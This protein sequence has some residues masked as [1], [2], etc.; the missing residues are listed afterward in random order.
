MAV[1]LICE[2]NP[3][4]NGHK[5]IIGEARRLTGEPVVAIMSGSF[6]QRGEA[7][8]C[9]KFDRARMALE[10]GADLVVELPTVYAV[11]G[12]QRF[13]QGGVE[14]AKSF[15][16]VRWL[17]FG[18]DCS[19]GSVLQEAADALQNPAVNARIAAQMRGG[20]Y[21][22]QAVERAVRS[23]CGDA[24]ADALT[25]PNNI[26][27]AEYL[28][29]LGGSDIRPLPVRRIGAAHD[30]DEVSGSY[31]SASK[32]RSMLR[33]GVAVDGLLP[34]VPQ[35]IT[36]P[37]L[38]E[39]ALLLRLRSMTAADFQKLPEVGEGLEHRIAAAVAENCSV[40]EILS[41]VKTKRYTHARL[42]RILCCAALGITEE[43]QSRRASYVRVLGFTGAGS[44]LLKSC[45]AEV[46][47]S[48]AKT[49][50]AGG[51]N[52]DF[53]RRDILASDLAA[54]AYDRVKPCGLDFY[55]KIIRLNRAE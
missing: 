46:V 15:G 51:A 17:A 29:A 50:R 48:A 3:F 47:T 44:L 18:C 43:L 27:A 42:R 10:N 8:I 11:A 53:L 9:S 39:R 2:F 26:L 21:Y 36:Y 41:A 33:T 13:A 23:V 25:S 28:R 32:L 6:T 37:D 16:E 4:H 14:I 35:E 24:A 31:V 34:E 40:E 5:Y 1:A 45:S 30:S 55:T 22:P 19:D 7:A 54:L 49:L 12:A 52:V 20:A 38:L